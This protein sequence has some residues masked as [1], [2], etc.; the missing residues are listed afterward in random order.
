MVNTK[1]FAEEKVEKACG[2]DELPEADEVEAEGDA[3][4]VLVALDGTQ[5]LGGCL[6][7][8]EDGDDGRLHTVEHACIYIIGCDGGEVYAGVLVLQLDAYRVGPPDDGPL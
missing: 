5:Y 2:E 7:G 3:L 1:D 8:V 6:R 4:E